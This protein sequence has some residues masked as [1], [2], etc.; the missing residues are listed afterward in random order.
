MTYSL[1]EIISG[2]V[3]RV[4]TVLSK[5]EPPRVELTTQQEDFPVGTWSRFPES[6]LGINNIDLVERELATLSRLSQF[7][8]PT[9][10]VLLE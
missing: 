3:L 5:Y 6:F 4:Y 8:V 7:M 2:L 9:R 1:N 10:P